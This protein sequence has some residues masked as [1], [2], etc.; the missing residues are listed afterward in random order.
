MNT[1]TGWGAAQFVLEDIDLLIDVALKLKEE[2][3]LFHAE[4]H[5]DNTNKP[6]SE[7]RWRIILLDEMLQQCE[8]D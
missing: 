2:G 5:P 1:D 8:E 6:N 4:P 7:R 3:V